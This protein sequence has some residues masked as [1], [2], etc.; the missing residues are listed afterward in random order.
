MALKVKLSIATAADGHS[1]LMKPEDKITLFCARE[2]WNA[3]NWSFNSAISI[4]VVDFSGDY[5][6]ILGLPKYYG[7]LVVDFMK[8]DM[9]LIA[10]DDV[11]LQKP[12]DCFKEGY[13]M[14]PPKRGTSEEHEFEFV[15]L[16]EDK[17]PI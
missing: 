11:I 15:L 7:H 6:D 4:G 2:Q 1:L 13:S 16:D 5:K 9:R 10:V 3:A 8:H 12:L 17:N 14:F